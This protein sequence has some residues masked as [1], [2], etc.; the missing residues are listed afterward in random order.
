MSQ[1]SYEPRATKRNSAS[2]GITNVALES[3][4]SWAL[5]RVT[6]IDA[7]QVRKHARITRRSRNSFAL[8]SRT[9]RPERSADS[10]QA[11]PNHCGYTTQYV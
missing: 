2:P 10:G 3:R 7:Y 11:F 4:C 8:R 9:L 5:A 6:M 1:C